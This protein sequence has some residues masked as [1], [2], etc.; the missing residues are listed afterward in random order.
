MN[1]VADHDSRQRV[2]QLDGSESFANNDTV[3]WL[4]DLLNSSDASAT[5]PRSRDPI[6][7]S[8]LEMD[9]PGLT[10][11]ESGLAEQ[12]GYR[13]HHVDPPAHARLQWTYH[14]ASSRACGIS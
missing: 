2:I 9:E 6:G 11:T 12:D 5:P 14:N 8:T 10:T 1:I 3:D 4:G 13:W 7:S